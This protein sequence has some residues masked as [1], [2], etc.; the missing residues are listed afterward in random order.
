M[1]AV[2]KLTLN[3]L[4]L[5]QIPKEYRGEILTFLWLQAKY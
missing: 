4:L 5:V 2:K 3:L 1:K